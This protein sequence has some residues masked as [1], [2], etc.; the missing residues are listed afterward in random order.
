MTD[1][2]IPPFTMNEEIT[3]MV[4]EIG[5][6]VGQLT[7]YDDFQTNLK[8]RRE[9]RI[10]T[11]HSSL[12]IE[13]NTLTIE[14]VTDVINGRKVLAPPQDIH[15]VKNAYEAYEELQKMNP[16]SIKDLL[17][18]HK[19]MMSG[20]VREAGVFRSGNVG[21]YS[22]DVLIHAGSPANYVPELM[23]DLFS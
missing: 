11:I 14:Q 5:E 7:V 3:N 9:N 1:K 23:K 10:K 16:Y 19:F 17:K 21:V 6:L 8:L 13:N 20:L 18:A 4:I 12:A 2:Y 22:G 15:E